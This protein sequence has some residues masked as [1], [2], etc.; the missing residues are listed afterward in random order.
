M[1]RG[2][3]QEGGG[4][5]LAGGPRLP[6]R[7][8]CLPHCREEIGLAWGRHANDGDYTTAALVW[9]ERCGKGEAGV[10]GGMRIRLTW[11]SCA[12]TLPGCMRCWRKHPPASHMLQPITQ[13]LRRAGSLPAPPAFRPSA[14]CQGERCCPPGARAAPKLANRS[15]RQRAQL[16]AASALATSRMQRTVRRRLLL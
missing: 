3:S 13:T 9:L 16:A 10:A 2:A 15:Q 1:F 11:R 7:P 6:C 14:S 5:G 12:A 4:Q 8:A